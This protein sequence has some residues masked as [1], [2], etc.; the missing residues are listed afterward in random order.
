[1]ENYTSIID[2]EISLGELVS[3]LE[4]GNAS[5]LDPFKL[6]INT[7][8]G[9]LFLF[10]IAY[11]KRKYQK[12]GLPCKVDILSLDR[13]REIVIHA[14]CEFIV[15]KKQLGR[16]CL[17]I[18]HSVKKQIYFMNWL[19]SNAFTFP[20]NLKSARKIYQKYTDV[21]SSDYKLKKN[22]S[23]VSQLKQD[24][25]CQLLSKSLSC[26]KHQISSGYTKFKSV[27][28]DRN[29][30]APA[31]EGDL[32]KHL[33]FHNALFNEIT[34]NILEDTKF[35]FQINLPNESL[36]VFP[37]TMWCAPLLRRNEKGLV[38]GI[39]DA[40]CL[41]TGKIKGREE[42][43][44]ETGRT[45]SRAADDIKWALINLEKNQ[46]NQSPAR[47]KVAHIAC[48]SYFMLFLVA[49]GMSDTTASSLPWSNDY[50]VGH[51]LHGFKAIKFRAD[52]KTVEFNIQSK[53]LQDFHRY[54]KI[55][56]YFLQGEPFPNLFFSISKNH[57]KPMVINVGS[58]SR[59][60]LKL[61]RETIDQ[62]LP[63]ILSRVSRVSKAKKVTDEYGAF[64]AAKLLQSSLQTIYSNYTGG[65]QE[66]ADREFGNFFDQLKSVVVS[67]DAQLTETI[68]GHC[69]SH[70]KPGPIIA[71]KI[72]V[73][74]STMHGCLFCDKYR[75]HADPSDVRKLLSL[76]FVINKTD[77]LA[78][79]KDDFISIFGTLLDRVEDV[80]KEISS[81]SDEAKQYVK[82]II[83]DVEINENLTDYW[84]NKLEILF[85]LGVF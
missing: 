77:V 5:F 16:S 24:A 45:L 82:T 18:F 22:N 54:L 49:T 23:A 30:T 66:D 3:I 14:M 43:A 57:N 62:T 11:L 7:G 8:K 78:K 26:A 47:I 51:D 69:A 84:S 38:S 1:M 19:D 48:K 53:A 9:R 59:L 41:D 2:V 35:P 32:K 65:N 52:N 28:A 56:D 27:G 61:F 70:N 10:Q 25:A 39:S 80:L 42:L 17:T 4:S 13:S 34:T 67:A 71:T 72:P 58:Y 76:K 12:G 46:S 55:R 40:W 75:V 36:W 64:V 33:Q 37:G 44:N 6:T 15:E 79:S 81:T 68:V 60:I 50:K 20:N 31:S 74:C 83:E 85:H 63:N 73:D 29:P 21:L